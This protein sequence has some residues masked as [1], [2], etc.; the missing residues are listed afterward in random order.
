MILLWLLL[1]VIWVYAAYALGVGKGYDGFVCG[2]AGFFGGIFAIVIVALLP[3][4]TEEISRA[5]VTKSNHEKE[6]AELKRRI[7]ELELS[8]A[9]E[10]PK[11]EMGEME[12][13]VEFSADEAATNVA[14]F[15]ARTE[16][17]IAC[18]CCG[19]RQ[20]GNRDACYSCGTLFQYE[21]EI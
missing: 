3:D 17:N 14:E 8:K 13:S 11:E 6:I 2:L 21:N 15:P 5:Q 1:R 19:K 16:E 12:K 4:K 10:S 20:R 18:P 9:Q 7:A